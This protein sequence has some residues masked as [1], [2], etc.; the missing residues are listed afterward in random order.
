MPS[1]AMDF[2]FYPNGL[3]SPS[4]LDVTYDP[5]MIINEGSYLLFA[6]DFSDV[7]NGSMVYTEKMPNP[8]TLDGVMSPEEKDVDLKGR[9]WY[10]V[11][12]ESK[13]GFITHLVFDKRLK[14]VK[15][16][17]IYIDD[18]TVNMKPESEPGQHFIGFQAAVKQFIKGKYDMNMYTYMNKSWTKG[19]EKRYLEFI[20]HP[21]KA[22]SRKVL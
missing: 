9:D 8:V 20:T 22:Q 17:I 1:V 4:V 16:D 10:V 18:K 15:T 12:N 5:E 11:Y 2:L 19:M 6:L 14:N 13:T 7:N 21:L 3:I